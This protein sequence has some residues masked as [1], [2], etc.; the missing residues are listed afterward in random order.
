MILSNKSTKKMIKNILIT[1]GAGFIGSHLCE[2]YLKNN[3]KVTVID[4]LLT[5]SKRNI[6]FN[7]YKNFTFI[8]HDVC[9]VINIKNN[10][11]FIFHMASPASPK[12]YY[13]FPIRTIKTGIIGTVNVLDFALKNNTPILLASSS[14]IYGDA[15]IN[16]Q[17]EDYFGNVNT[18]GPRSV[19]D[20]SKRVL[21]TLGYSYNK[22]FNIDVKIARIFNT[23]G[24]RMNISDGRVIPNFINQMI[25]NKAVTIYGNGTQTR[26]FCYIDDTVEGLVRLMESNYQKPI[27]IGNNNEITIIELFNKLNSLINNDSKIKYFELPEND[28]LKRQP[29][30]SLAKKILN[31]HPKI[32][33]NTG[34]KKTINY[35]SNNKL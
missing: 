18:V 4:N 10:F 35:Y 17:T 26:S 2:L 5:G 14:E 8:E 30:I 33:L 3:H 15:K 11:D 29:N 24:P 6:N 1:G 25:N 27:N 23:Y 31:W 16:P 32:N 22:K 34:L 12:A 9:E 21:E 20:E 19:Y 7:S 13:S 28:P